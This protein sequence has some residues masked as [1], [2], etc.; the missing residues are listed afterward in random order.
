MFDKAGIDYPKEGWL[1]LVS[2]KLAKKLTVEENGR[3]EQYGIASYSWEEAS[4]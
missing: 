3:I 2:W 4:Y 1:M